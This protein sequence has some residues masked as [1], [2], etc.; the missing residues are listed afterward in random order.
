MGALQMQLK[1]VQK[2]DEDFR[3]TQSPR[4]PSELK[5]NLNAAVSLEHQAWDTERAIQT[6]HFRFLKIR[7]R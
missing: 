5:E 2:A 3:K 1:A 6:S 7:R 4:S